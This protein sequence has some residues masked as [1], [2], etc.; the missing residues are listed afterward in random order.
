MREANWNTVVL[1]ILQYERKGQLEDCCFVYLAIRE[2]RT[3]GSLLL[4]LYC[5]MRK[6]DNWKTAVLLILKYER[7]G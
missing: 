3:T 4:C 1:L 5:N 2:R 6:K 7:E